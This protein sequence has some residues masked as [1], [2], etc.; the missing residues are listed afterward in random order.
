[1]SD[2]CDDADAF[3]AEMDTIIYESQG[4]TYSST[5][6][7]I[8]KRGNL[9]SGRGGAPINKGERLPSGDKEKDDEEASTDDEWYINE[10]EPVDDCQST[11]SKKF[12]DATDCLKD[13]SDSD[14]NGYEPCLRNEWFIHDSDDEDN[15]EVPSYLRGKF[16]E[17]NK[18]GTV[19]L[20]LGHMFYDKNHFLEALRDFARL[21]GFNMFR[22]KYARHRFTTLCSNGKECP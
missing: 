8:I 13:Y 9:I 5:I 6:V 17:S 21:N 16:F 4:R 1:M 22:F 14:S 7:P 10:L 20:E 3:F 19:S 12:I 2:L 11:R 15:F 18:D